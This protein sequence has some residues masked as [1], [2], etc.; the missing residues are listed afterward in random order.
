MDAIRAAN[1]LTNND[2]W[3]AAWIRANKP[4]LAEGEVE[5]GARGRREGRRRRGMTAALPWRETADGVELAVRLTPR[6]GAARIEGIAD[7]DGQPCLKVR[8]AAPPVD[9]AANDALVACLAR[10]LRLPAP[11]SP[12]RRRP[13]PREAPAPRGGLAT[14]RRLLDANDRLSYGACNL[15]SSRFPSTGGKQTKNRCA[16]RAHS[17]AATAASRRSAARATPVNL[18]C[19][20]VEPDRKIV[21]ISAT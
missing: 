6:G 16:H 7:R 21:A 17:L 3:G 4:P 11:P 10:A 15:E 1:L 8:V 19:H 5:A 2:P 9:G 12:C 20:A 13:R 14:P 18:G